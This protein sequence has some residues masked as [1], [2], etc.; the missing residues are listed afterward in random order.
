MSLVEDMKSVLLIYGFTTPIVLGRMPDLPDT[1]LMLR[2]YEAGRNRDFTAKNLPVFESLAAQMWIRVGKDHGIR[3]AELI[4][5]S[6]YRMLSG[7]HIRINGNSYD[8]WIASFSPTHL[9]TDEL[10]RPIVGTNWSAQR[11]GDVSIPSPP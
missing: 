10:D 7:R 2:E 3:S 6:A 9:F 8:R 11:W 4:A 1:V 5:V